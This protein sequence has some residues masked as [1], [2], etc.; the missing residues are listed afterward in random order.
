MD[1]CGGETKENPMD[2]V[3]IIVVRIGMLKFNDYSSLKVVHIKIQ[4]FVQTNPI[5]EV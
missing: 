5:W 1:I 3:P 4:L 2:L